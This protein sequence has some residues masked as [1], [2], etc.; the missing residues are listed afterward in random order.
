MFFLFEGQS[1]D[2]EGSEEVIDIADTR[3]VKD[4]E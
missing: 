2:A 3:I 4:K 1:S